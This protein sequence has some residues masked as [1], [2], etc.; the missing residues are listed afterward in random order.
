M[1]YQ[2]TLGTRREFADLM[3][4]SFGTRFSV[5]ACN[6]LYTDLKRGGWPEVRLIVDDD[7]GRF[8]A[9]DPFGSGFAIDSL[10]SSLLHKY[11]DAQK[12]PRGLMRKALKEPE[13]L[14]LLGFE[15]RYIDVEALC[16]FFYWADDPRAIWDDMKV[17][18]ARERARDESS[19]LE[20]ECR[21][22]TAGKSKRG[23]L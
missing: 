6:E 15:V 9:Y 14:L 12:V 16:G 22:A 11:S 8:F 23:R 20:R 21:A 10:L 4:R 19:V 18:E 5:A 13:E 17:V 1:S 3:R 7:A 2:I